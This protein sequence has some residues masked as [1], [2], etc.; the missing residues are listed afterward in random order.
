VTGVIYFAHVS[1]GIAHAFELSLVELAALGLAL[2]GAT[3]LLP[4]QASA[5]AAVPA[6]A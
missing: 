2:V 1:T 5:P 6:G 3:R 4:Q